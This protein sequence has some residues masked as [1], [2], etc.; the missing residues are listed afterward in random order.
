MRRY[1]LRRLG[2]LIPT[3]LLI[4]FMVFALMHALPGDPA[5][6]LVAGGEALDET[7]LAVVRHELNLDK[8]MPVQYVLWLGKALSLDLGLPPIEIT[9][10]SGCGLKIRTR[11]GNGAARSGREVSSAW[12]LPPGQPVMVCCSSLNTRMLIS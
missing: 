3:L 7:Q 11:F 4:T 9:S 2:Q 10:S 8:P 6:A 12:G 5:R 1:I